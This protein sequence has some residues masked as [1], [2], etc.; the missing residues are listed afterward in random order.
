VL[1]AGHRHPRCLFCQRHATYIRRD[2]RTSSG[3]SGP[4]QRTTTM[5]NGEQGVSGNL[6]FARAIRSGIAD[7]KLGQ[8]RRP[9]SPTVF[10]ADNDPPSLPC[11]TRIPVI[12]IPARRCVINDRRKRV[13]L[14]SLGSASHF[15]RI[16][17]GSSCMHK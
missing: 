4:R 6:P 14:S 10:L 17:R 5:T 15:L 3:W 7:L 13:R 1:A 11:I 8:T 16:K 2:R 9:P 12:A